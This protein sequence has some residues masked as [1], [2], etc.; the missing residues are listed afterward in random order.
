MV[1]RFYCLQIRF[2][3]TW[4]NIDFTLKGY[5]FGVFKLTKNADFN[6]YAYSRY[7]IRYDLLWIFLISN[8]DFSN[9]VTIFCCG[10]WFINSCRK[11][12]NVYFGY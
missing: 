3:A 8:F 5:L 9:N 6:N 10:Q 11:Y 12:Q 2:I 4:F 7:R 1:Q